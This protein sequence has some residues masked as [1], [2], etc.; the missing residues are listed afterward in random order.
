MNTDNMLKAS[1]IMAL[2]PQ[3]PP[4]IR[5][6]M[7]YTLLELLE[8]KLSEKELKDL[9]EYIQPPSWH[10]NGG[11]TPVTEGHTT[12]ST[13]PVTEATHAS[14]CLCDKCRETTDQ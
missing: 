5:E 6:R 2:M 10:Q 3:M 4:S 1:I 8:Y 13:T 7:M 12:I 14:D 9:H 11:W